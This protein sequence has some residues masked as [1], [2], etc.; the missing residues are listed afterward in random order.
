MGLPDFSV[1]KHD[2]TFSLK[3]PKTQLSTRSLGI[4]SPLLPLRITVT[5]MLHIISFW[6]DAQPSSRPRPPEN[7]WECPLVFASIFPGLPP[8][9]SQPFPADRPALLSNPH[10]PQDGVQKNACLVNTSLTRGRH[11]FF[12]LHFRVV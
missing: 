10:R 6:R 2:V 1:P 12:C 11:V 5:F 4:T 8:L 7:L 3:S 9:R